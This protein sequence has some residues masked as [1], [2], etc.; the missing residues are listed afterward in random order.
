MNM[1]GQF[2][3]I[4]GIVIVVVLLLIKNSLDLAQ[5]IENKRS[6]ET[7]MEKKE[8]LNVKDELLKTID[9]SYN[10]NESEKIENFIVYVRQRLKA[11]A[12]ELDGIAIETEVNNVVENSPVSLNVT[13][14]NFLGESIQSLNLNFSCNGSSQSL[15]NIPDNSSRRVEFTF[16][17]SNEN[18]SL[19]VNYTT[20]KE[21]KQYKIQILVEIGK[22]K[23]FGFF[24]LRMKGLTS[25]I[26]DEFLKVV[27]TF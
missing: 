1:K 11:K 17:G 3:L 25:E 23:F 4:S 18:C 22:N 6:L 8:F 15:S 13:I 9:Y 21:S 16:I 26:R 7:S 20:P 10:K 27:E 12:I 24:D 5:I 19:N 2:F 14:F